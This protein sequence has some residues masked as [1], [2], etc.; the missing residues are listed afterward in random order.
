MAGQLNT[1]LNEV[2]TKL[3]SSLSE[4][5]GDATSKADE[6][7]SR[8]RSV[9]D[10]AK[11]VGDSIDTEIVPGLYDA[12]KATDIFGSDLETISNIFIQ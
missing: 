1:Q 6:F 4:P 5:I 10:D 3:I 11:A 9:S 8:V 7:K 2:K 12:I